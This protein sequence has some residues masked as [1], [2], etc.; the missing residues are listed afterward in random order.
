MRCTG[1]T[2]FAVVFPLKNAEPPTTKWKGKGIRIA[3]GL[4]VVVSMKEKEKNTEP[5][6]L[7]G[8]ER[9][10]HRIQFVWVSSNAQTVAINEIN[11]IRSGRERPQNRNRNALYKYKIEH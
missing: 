1:S 2:Q 8:N 4:P 10:A 9:K 11:G 6:R 5:Q 3:Y 7:K